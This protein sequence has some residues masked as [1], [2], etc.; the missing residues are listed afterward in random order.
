MIVFKQKE[1]VAPGVVMALGGWGN[2]AML[3][4]TVG[5]TAIGMKQSSDS[6]KQNEE[7]AEQQRRDNAKTRA[8]LEKLANSNVSSEKK[9]E[10]SSLFS[11]R[12]MFAA[13]PGGFLK[14][15]G[16]LAKDLWAHSGSGVKSAAKMGA[17]FAAAGYVGNKVASGLKNHDEGEDKKTLSGLAKVGAATAA[18]VGGIWAAKNGHLG[19]GAKKFMTTGRGGKFVDT[20]KKVLTENINPIKK[21]PKNKLGIG[22]RGSAAMSL[23]FG[24]IPVATYLA[25][26][27]S[28]ND[29]VEG[30]QEESGQR[31]YAIPGAG[32]VKGIGGW[33][34]RAGNGLKTDW[35]RT[36]SGGF[37]KVASQFGMMGGKGGTTAVKKGAEKLLEQGNKSGNVYTQNLAKWAL[38]NPN[39]ANLA[40]GAATLAVGTTAMGLGEKMVTK[41]M[42]AID[43][44]AYKMEEQ[45]NGQV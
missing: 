37:N 16:G 32:M 9:A 41:P 28:K 43:R 7:L 27:K 13:P 22:I 15:V 5:S 26:R 4:T 19:Q 11:E 38:N 17:G 3:G 14:N 20:A 39:K 35:K 44:D 31:Q 8:A 18:T 12:R 40:A 45:E 29:M 2:T 30:T 34:K 42:K 25:Q 10:A 36:L 1:Y 6:E 33:F 23:G 21:D 24:A